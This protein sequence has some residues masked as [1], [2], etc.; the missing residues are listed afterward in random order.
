MLLGALALIGVYLASYAMLSKTGGW[1]VAESGETRLMSLANN[2][3]YLWQPRYGSCQWFRDI[4]GEY[5]LRGDALGYLYAPLILPI[6]AGFTGPF[7][8][9]IPISASSSLRPCR[10]IRN[11]IPCAKI[12]SPDVSLMRVLPINVMPRV[13]QNDGWNQ[14]HPG[15]VDLL[16][17]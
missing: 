15:K 13:R 3:I 12:V 2:D 8:F 4:G 14:R 16:Y 6:S 7:A 1:V 9:S 17:E 5:G 11:S 10:L